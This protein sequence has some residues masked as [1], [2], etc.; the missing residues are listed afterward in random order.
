MPFAWRST[1]TLCAPAMLPCSNVDIAPLP[2]VEQHTL[3]CG[4]LYDRRDAPPSTGL[5]VDETLSGAMAECADPPVP[6]VAPPSLKVSKD[7]LTDIT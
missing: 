5:S 3:A 6:G 7:L 4:V 1:T 2:D